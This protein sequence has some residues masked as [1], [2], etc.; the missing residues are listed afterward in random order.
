MFVWGISFETECLQ[1]F[2]LLVKFSA[3]KTCNMKDRWNISACC[4]EVYT[5]TEI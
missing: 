5:S 4:V 3:E 2:I 1:T